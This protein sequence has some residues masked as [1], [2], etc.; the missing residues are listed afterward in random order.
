MDSLRHSYGRT[1]KGSP[2]QTGRRVGPKAW[3]D[4]LEWRRSFRSSF[5]RTKSFRGSAEYASRATNEFMPY[6]DSFPS[7]PV[8]SADDPGGRD[9][10]L[11]LKPPSP[12]G[13]WDSSTPPYPP[14]SDVP[15][16]AFHRGSGVRRL[17]EWSSTPTSRRQRPS[18][19]RS[20]NPSRS[21]RSAELERSLPAPP[22]PPPAAAEE[23]SGKEEAS[24]ARVHPWFGRTESS[25]G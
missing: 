8:P 20:T 21:P 10:G 4:V 25:P 23:G 13:M 24:A 5:E 7:R 15:T 16:L 17:R 11:H 22:L 3:H 6:G 9:P 19:T 1:R 12:K 18:S 14:P 2:C